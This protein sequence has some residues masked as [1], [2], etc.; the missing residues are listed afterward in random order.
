MY[1][2]T[3]A[4]IR[5]NGLVEERWRKETRAEGI[6]WWEERLRITLHKVDRNVGTGHWERA[7]G[8]ADAWLLARPLASLRVQ[9]GDGTDFAANFA[10]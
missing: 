7:R 8:S 4:I 10:A 3:I 9:V 1:Y 6:K 2:T 5:C